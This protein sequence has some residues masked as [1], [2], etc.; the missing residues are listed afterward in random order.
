MA[1][2]DDVFFD[3]KLKRLDR[4]RCEA[5][6][7]EC[8]GEAQR[9]YVAREQFVP[10]HARTQRFGCIV[11]HRRAGK[12]VA[13]IHELQACA[14]RCSKI[15]PRFAYVSPFLKQSKTVA[16]DYLR[17]AAALAKTGG[18]IHESELRVDY[19]NSG[20]VRLYGADNPDAL[21]GIYLDGVVLD[22]YA[23]MDPRLC[24]RW[25]A[26]LWPIARA[27]PCSSARRKAGTRCS[28]PGRAP[29]PTRRTGTR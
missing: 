13:S 8:A 1:D 19:P 25:S 18:T 28:R 2:W 16:W 10:F 29:P 26:R 11:T 9:T 15:R 23:D 22:E 6:P 24:P 5:D 4:V 3:R 20:Q 21:R 14:L 12:T 27:G 7:R 17:E